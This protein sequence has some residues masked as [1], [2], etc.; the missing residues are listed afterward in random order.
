[1]RWPGNNRCPPPSLRMDERPHCRHVRGCYPANVL[2]DPG[3]K[4]AAQLLRDA[5]VLA[6]QAQGRFTTAALLEGK[7]AGSGKAPA[8]ADYVDPLEIFDSPTA[9]RGLRA[10]RAVGAGELLLVERALATEQVGPTARLCWEGRSPHEWQKKA[11]ADTRPPCLSLHP[12]CCPVHAAEPTAL[13]ST[14]PCPRR[15]REQPSLLSTP[16]GAWWVAGEGMPRWLRHSSVH[17][18]LPS[19]S[20]CMPNCLRA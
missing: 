10:T 13:L 4:A 20:C 5:T 6:E 12:G 8:S 11:C 17:P 7:A 19:G 14:L 15:R 3:F 2:Q 16:R 18:C 1:M 9:G